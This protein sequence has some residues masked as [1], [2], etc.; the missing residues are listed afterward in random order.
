MQCFAPS[1]RPDAT[2]WQGSGK[3]IAD[4]GRGKIRMNTNSS[5]QRP[6]LL[7]VALTASAA[8]SIEWYDFFIYGTAAA[9]VFPQL[10]FPADISPFVAQLASFSAFAVGFIAR[11]A[12]G[13]IFGHIGD[14]V[15]RKRALVIALLLMGVAT[16]LVGLLPTYAMAGALAPC[17]LVL[18]RIIQGIAVGGQWG[19][20]ALLAIESAPPDR[21]GFYGSFVQV[22]VPVGVVLANA[23]FL[24]AN[25]LL[26]PEE[27]LAWGWRIPFLLSIGLV[28]IGLY[29]QFRL[30]ESAE[31][32]KLAESAPTESTTPKAKSPIISLILHHPKRVLL[33]GGAF[34]ANN[35]CFYIAITYIVA[36]GTTTL[37]LSRSLML[38]AVLISSV[39]MIPVLVIFGRLSDHFERRHVF[40]AGAA[41]TGLWS[42]AMFPLLETGS[43]PLVILSIAG[44]LLLISVMYGPQAAFFAELFPVHIRYSG[45]SLGYQLG[46]VVGGG[47]APIIAATLLEQF[48]DS[49]AIAVYLFVIC[50][51]S[52]GCTYLLSHRP[53]NNDEG[54][55]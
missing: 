53:T 23:V 35:A 37:G 32:Q 55:L 38:S 13:I 30:E 21:Q 50:L 28:G 4:R 12:G 48:H 20:A 54:I 40:M 36:Y 25:M 3:C 7:K 42:F 47:L 5:Q 52:L 41:L 14:L 34:A 29:A 51:I 16:T 11:P 46:T 26:A 8:A 44:E 2:L 45:A 6:G 18:L 19:G 1:R 10:F 17:L 27:F 22:G 24:I 39:A 15:G 9:L 43:P 31:F 49:F 33:A